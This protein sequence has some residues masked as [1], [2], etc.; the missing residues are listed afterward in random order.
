MYVG[1]VVKKF[2]FIPTEKSEENR[3]PQE[4]DEVF[5]KASASKN[6]LKSLF[7]KALITSLNK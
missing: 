5:P 3:N 1:C 7:L 6:Y 2:F 4:K